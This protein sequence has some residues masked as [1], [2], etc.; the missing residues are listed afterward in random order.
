MRKFI[1]S[2]AVIGALASLTLLSSAAPADAKK[3]TCQ[4]KAQACERRCA[5]NYSNWND[6][7]YRTCTKQYGSCGM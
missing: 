6:C 3:M 4:A 1:Y 2:T 5:A 7:V